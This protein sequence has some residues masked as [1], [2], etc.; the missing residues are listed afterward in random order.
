MNRPISKKFACAL[1]YI[2]DLHLSNF[3]LL[4]LIF[5]PSMALDLCTKCVSPKYLP[6]KW[7]HFEKILLVLLSK[8]KMHTKNERSGG[9]SG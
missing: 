4:F 6:N 3:I 1:I 9:V 5:Q 8:L 7:L 2:Y